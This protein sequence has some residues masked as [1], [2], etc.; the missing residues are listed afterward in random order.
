MTIDIN[1]H[2]RDRLDSQFDSSSLPLFTFALDTL[3][4][5]EKSFVIYSMPKY[6]AFEL[7]YSIVGKEK[8]FTSD[9]DWN[10]GTLNNVTVSSGTLTGE[11]GGGT[12]TSPAL[13]WS[14]SSF[15]ETIDNFN[16]LNFNGNWEAYTGNGGSVEIATD[17][18]AN[19][20]KYLLA[21]T[22]STSDS[23]IYLKN[24]T[25]TI[26]IKEKAHV[27]HKGNVVVKFYSPSSGWGD[28]FTD[29][30]DWSYRK[31]ITIT[32]NSGTNLTDFQVAITVDTQ[33]LISAGKMQ[34]DGADIRFADNSGN[35]LDYW[36]ESGINTTSTKI[37]VKVPSLSASTDT[38]IYMFYGNPSASSAS[39]G[40]DTFVFFDD[41]EGTSLDLN[42]WDTSSAHYTTVNDGVALFY[43]TSSSWHKVISKST[44][45][46][47]LLWRFRARA[48][49]YGEKET[50]G[51]DY[52]YSRINFYCYNNGHVYFGYTGSDLGNCDWDWHVYM[53]ITGSTQKAYIDDV[54]VAT[55]NW[56]TGT[57]AIGSNHKI[58]TENHAGAYFEWVFITKYADPE[59]TY[60]IGSEETQSSGVGDLE[61]T[62]T[63]TGNPTSW[64]LSEFDTSS[65]SG[66]TIQSIVIESNGTDYYETDGGDYLRFALDAIWFE[67]TSRQTTWEQ[68]DLTYSGSVTVDV[69][70]ASDD[71]VLQS[72]LSGTT[73][74]LKSYSNLEG[75]NIKIRL[76]IPQ[77]GTV[78]DMTVSWK[79]DLIGDN[80]GEK[81]EEMSL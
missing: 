44:F 11:T 57:Y 31:E 76:N 55:A 1:P 48:K 59:P 78:D 16:S 46:T 74:D 18:I 33:S 68:I 21:K 14:P 47:S 73:I 67:D 2:R 42:K 38:T 22:S 70:D 9:E 72:N 65:K 58:D 13:A 35:D 32:E 24:L 62:L 25:D 28:P 60:S 8:I 69:L 29:Y 36:I 34:S 15:F 40:D 17:L 81:T 4:F 49:F 43:T 64:T 61:L 77:S 26:K 5:T 3:T 71:T 19:G 54:Q 7:G 27:L 50:I 75:K 79:P 30:D 37:W 23:V 80:R 51:F 53:I 6:D 66:T 12:W 63:T 41:F 45:D 56:S 39:S 20:H 52:D 10:S